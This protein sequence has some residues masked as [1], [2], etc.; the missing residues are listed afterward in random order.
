MLPDRD[1]NK[2]LPPAVPSVSLDLAD[3][4]PVHRHDDLNRVGEF[5]LAE[6]RLDFLVHL[7][8]TGV[9]VDVGVIKG[10]D[11]LAG[12]VRLADGPFEL[13]SVHGIGGPRI[14]RMLFRV[15]GVKAALDIPQDVDAL[16]RAAAGHDAA[17]LVRV[18]RGRLAV[19]GVDGILR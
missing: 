16:N 5:R 9:A 7:G 13:S 17:A 1:R 11:R 19:D 3:L 12:C 8:K 18:L 4:P 6:D 15:F 10:K 2:I 14:T